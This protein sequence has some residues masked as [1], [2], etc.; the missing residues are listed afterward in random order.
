MSPPP[1]NFQ[2]S[3]LRTNHHVP[4]LIRLRGDDRFL[5]SY[6][7]HDHIP[8]NVLAG[9][10][11]LFLAQSSVQESSSE[12]SGSDSDEDDEEGDSDSTSP[13]RISTA[14][15]EGGET[16]TARKKNLESVK[17]ESSSLHPGGSADGGCAV[18]E[19][20]SYLLSRLATESSTLFSQALEHFRVA[21]GLE[22]RQPDE[23]MGEGTR[24]YTLVS[25][26]ERSEEDRN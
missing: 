8:L 5:P 24:W 9:Q 3:L 4:T 1:P 21:K 20:L 25:L 7:Y 19:D 18:D 17:G 2:P 23:A 6:P 15:G 26:I 12:D 11:A 14:P 22:E 10:L 16:G 13:E